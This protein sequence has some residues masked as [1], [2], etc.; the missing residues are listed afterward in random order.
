[1]P[2]SLAI[3]SLPEPYAPAGRPVRIELVPVSALVLVDRGQHIHETSSKCDQPF[4]L[5]C[6][7]EPVSFSVN[8]VRFD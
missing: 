4:P 7:V 6:P 8:H 1:M 2:N 5:G 3:C